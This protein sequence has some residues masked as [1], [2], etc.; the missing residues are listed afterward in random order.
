MG[1]RGLLRIAPWA[2]VLLVSAGG[3]RA[4]KVFSPFGSEFLLQSSSLLYDW[5][6][7][8]QDSNRAFRM[9][10]GGDA[11][12]GGALDGY[13]YFSELTPAFRATIQVLDV[14]LSWS[15]L[16]LHRPTR[17]KY[18]PDALRP[19]SWYGV[20]GELRGSNLSAGFYYA[21]QGQASISADS[22]VSQT[23]DS[24]LAM[25]TGVR[26]GPVA[27]DFLFT[28]QVH[29]DLGPVSSNQDLLAADQ[30]PAACENFWFSNT[31]AQA[32]FWV[33]RVVL[34]GDG[35]V[36]VVDATT[37]A[38]PPGFIW[39][40]APQATTFGE[41]RYLWFP[42]DAT[43][44]LSNGAGPRRWKRVTFT[45]AGDLA[46]L[47][48][49]SGSLET[50]PDRYR[51]IPWSIARMPA[52]SRLA[53]STA[54]PGY[55]PSSFRRTVTFQLDHQANEGLGVNLH[56]QGRQVQG[57]LS[58]AVNE[59]DQ[60]GKKELRQGGELS[61][62]TRLP[63][64][65]AT[66]FVHAHQ[67][68]FSV[69]LDGDPAVEIRS[70][71][72]GPYGLRAANS[73]DQLLTAA[74]VSPGF[75]WYYENPSY[76]FRALGQDQNHNGIQDDRETF[77]SPDHFAASG[78]Y[79]EARLA[80]SGRLG[81]DLG[82]TALVDGRWQEGAPMSSLA[83]IL[84]W[85][86]SFGPRLSV[87]AA[88][89]EEFMPQPNRLPAHSLE[90]ADLITPGVLKN[91]VLA[92]GEATAQWLGF[93]ARAEA[94]LAHRLFEAGAWRFELTPA[95]SLERPIPLSPVVELIPRA[96]FL[97][98]LQRGPWDSNQAPAPASNAF[99]VDRSALGAWGESFLLFLL[100]ARVRYAAFQWFSGGECSFYDQEAPGDWGLS[101]VYS[102][103]TPLSRLALTSRLEYKG[104]YLGRPM[105]LA[106]TVQA[107]IF[108]AARLSAL[109]ALD[110]WKRYS[111]I[112]VRLYTG[113]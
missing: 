93:S 16:L 101:G 82:W 89:M 64:A 2:C 73:Q 7:E 33:E 90:Q 108:A 23:A 15:P 35:G 3:L 85:R 59:K 75:Y 97:F 109:P 13:V 30:A 41:R 51:P 20:L 38:P 91:Q 43:L 37:T 104:N 28:H 77:L 106:L 81:A 55:G 25:R 4:Q 49:R 14:P 29:R 32:G 96:R 6:L 56:W 36:E 63:G 18:F 62:M 60:A 5:T 79:G 105:G 11:S 95:L 1:L 46:I 40:L 65:L 110:Q 50:R 26:L 88:A 39:S 80:F 21:G 47:R 10:L 24:M 70:A 92:L 100:E 48:N 86:R 102:I 17:P 103:S 34:A 67:D 66:L 87:T 83:L 76:Y 9:N 111:S 19:L 57:R 113:F 99:V 12:P 61:L 94:N 22:N 68:G 52:G 44:A 84:E 74:G 45:Y 42:G 58:W 69:D 112:L 107:G 31:G 98:H 54:F 72:L 27:A 71:P 78:D 8:S 53:P